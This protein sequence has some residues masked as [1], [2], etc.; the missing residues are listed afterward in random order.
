MDTRRTGLVLVTG[1]T[2]FVGRHLVHALLDAG[3]PVRCLVRSDP[4]RLALSGT[5]GQPQVAS[6][7]ISDPNSLQ[8]AFL[9]VDTVVH[10]VGIIRERPGSS[11]WGVHVEGTANVLAASVRCG[12]RRFLYMSALGTRPDARSR[13]HKSKWAAEQNVRNSGLQHA[14]MRPSVIYGPGDGFVS[15]LADMIRRAPLVI[16][17][18][19]DGR[20]SLQPVWIGDLVQA[21]VRML[22]DDSLW[23]HTWEIGGPEALSL[24]EVI[25][26]I[27]DT[28]SVRKPPVHIPVAVMRPA[29]WV[30]QSLL[31]NPPLTTDQLLM[32]SEPNTCDADVLPSRFGLRPLHFRE[33]LARYLV[34]QR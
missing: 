11:F 33:G 21:I 18:P 8:T 4:S 32:L 15:T 31:P 25:Q 12:V 26:A 9:G 3:H 7:D 17:V 14:I 20:S 23:N 13:Y 24:N 5:P 6:G 2:G 1:A 28:L 19:G 34:G 10:L 22:S 29:A 27:A 30:M 16:P